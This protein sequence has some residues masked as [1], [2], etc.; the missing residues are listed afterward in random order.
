MFSAQPGLQPQAPAPAPA[1][2][3]IAVKKAPWLMLALIGAV[4]V[5]LALVVIM[6]F[7]LRK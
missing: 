6:A 5:L 4:V 2:A 7:A 3:P 1:P